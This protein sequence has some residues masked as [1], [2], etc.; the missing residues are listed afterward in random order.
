MQSISFLWN[1]VIFQILANLMVGNN[2]PFVISHSFACLFGIGCE[3]VCSRD[4]TDGD[5]DLGRRG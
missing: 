3:C 5:S 2:Y 4:I 1:R